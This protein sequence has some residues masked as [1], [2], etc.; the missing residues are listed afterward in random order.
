MTMQNEKTDYLSEWPAHY[1]EIE[2]INERERILKL[3]IE[4]KLDPAGDEKRLLVL[5]KRFGEKQAEK[6][7]DH[8]LHAWMMIQATGA[9]GVSFFQK[10][11]Q[12]KELCGYFSQLGIQMEETK[13]VEKEPDREDACGYVLEEEWKNFA[14]T[15]LASCT[16]SRAYC[17]TLFG[18]VPI[19]DAAVDERLPGSI[20]TGGGSASIPQYYGGFI[21]PVCSKWRSGLEIDAR[22]KM[23]IVSSLDGNTRH[24]FHIIV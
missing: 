4:Q 10:K 15:Y 2:D 16:G 22:M 21:L 20:W 23:E 8:F 3:A 6:R 18:I 19:K 13:N 12:K 5:K 14:Y 11:R 24:F 9:G 1:Y 7:A 17:S